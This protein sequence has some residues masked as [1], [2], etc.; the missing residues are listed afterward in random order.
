[1]KT[2]DVRDLPD[3]VAEAVRALR[4][5]FKKNGKHTLDELPVLHLGAT[6][7]LGR[8]EIHHDHLDKKLDSRP[9]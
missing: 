8:D 9:A 4:E 1:M 3:P 6:G 7:R 2:I 5:Q